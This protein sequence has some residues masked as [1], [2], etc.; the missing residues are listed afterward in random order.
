[1]GSD[2]LGSTVTDQYVE[3]YAQDTGFARAISEQMTHAFFI[4]PSRALARLQELYTIMIS[5]MP[6]I[7][8]FVIRFASDTAAQRRNI[9]YYSFAHPR[10]GEVCE[11]INLDPN[12]G[13]CT[14]ASEVKFVFRSGPYVK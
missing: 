2:S 10:E 11:G 6:N 1:M 14:H 13:Y 9:Y 7:L 8:F 12:C 4:C 5:T 3:W